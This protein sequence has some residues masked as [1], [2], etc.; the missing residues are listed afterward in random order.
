MVE[1]G[2]S[3]G[4]L[5]ELTLEWI[6]R[7]KTCTPDIIKRNFVGHLFCLLVNLIEVIL[8]MIHVNVPNKYLSTWTSYIHHMLWCH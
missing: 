1:L 2:K 3:R 8:L 7:L 6:L 5:K 4:R